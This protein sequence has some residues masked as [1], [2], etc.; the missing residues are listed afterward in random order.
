MNFRKLASKVYMLSYCC[1]LFLGNSQGLDQ[2]SQAVILEPCSLAWSFV[3]AP[4]VGDT[5][6]MGLVLT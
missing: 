6:I 4:S 3:Q 2:P 5:G 1:I